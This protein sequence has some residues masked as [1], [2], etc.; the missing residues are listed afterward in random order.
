MKTE[1]STGT[2][3]TSMLDRRQPGA[4]FMR[5][6]NEPVVLEPE[7]VLL[8]DMANMNARGVVETIAKALAEA[9]D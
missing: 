1:R 7:L 3:V 5:V 9:A 8:P 2:N 6:A 4:A